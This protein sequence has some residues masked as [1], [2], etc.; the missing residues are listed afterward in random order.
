MTIQELIAQTKTDNRLSTR[1]LARRLNIGESTIRSLIKG[2]RQPGRK[3]LYAL[4]A[5]FPEQR[6]AC[7]SIFFGSDAH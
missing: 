6:D 3:V 7:L 5:Q 2:T 1:A 4:A